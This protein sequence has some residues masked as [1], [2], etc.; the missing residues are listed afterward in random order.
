MKKESTL[1]GILRVM[2]P[3]PLKGEDFERFFVQTDAARGTSPAHNLTAFFRANGDKCQKVLFMGHEGSGKSTELFRFQ[4]MAADT[5]EVIPLSISDETDILDL[6]SADIM[7][8]VLGRLMEHAQ[9]KS[10]PIHPRLSGQPG[11]P[12]G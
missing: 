5:F 9:E 12:L 8:A 10:I 4:Q 6:H 7:L 2:R 11:E 3:D 1:E